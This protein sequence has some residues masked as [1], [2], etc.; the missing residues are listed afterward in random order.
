MKPEKR[1][2][3]FLLS[4]TRRLY[5]TSNPAVEQ[6]SAFILNHEDVYVSLC[7]C[8]QMGSVHVVYS[9]TDPKNALRYEI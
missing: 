9:L 6:L 1:E 8:G 5:T 4:L 2:L 3:P 7:L